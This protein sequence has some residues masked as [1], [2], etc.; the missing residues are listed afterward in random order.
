MI[1]SRAR[2]QIVLFVCLCLA[3]I[4]LVSCRRDKPKQAAKTEG[5]L[6]Y[7]DR[8]TYC[9]KYVLYNGSHGM[10]YLFDVSAGT[11]VPY[12]FDPGCEHK[13]AVRDTN[14]T[15][16]TEGCSAYDYSE[17]AVFLCDD[18]MYYFSSRCLYRAD[19]DGTNRKKIVEL[20]KPYEIRP[21]MCCYTDE[22]LYVSY[23]LSYEYTQTANADG[24]TVW[25]AGEFRE[26]PE[27]GLLRLPFSGG[28]EEVVFSSD[29]L[30]AMQVVEIWQH[31]KN[32]AFLVQ[33]MDRLTNYEEAD[34]EDW[35]AFSAEE[36]KHTFL[37]VYDYSV[38]DRTV[39]SVLDA[40]PNI[41]VYFYSEVYAIGRESGELEL[42][43]YSG[44]RVCSTE[45]KISPSVKCDRAIIGWDAATKE[46][47]M[48]SEHTGKIEK[49]SSLTW[50]DIVLTVTVGDSYYGSVTNPDGRS[51][52][53]YISAN[54][55]WAGNKSGIVVFPEEGEN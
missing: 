29:E 50:E 52:R 36:K 26:K 42:F 53:A 16:I 43:N 11:A 12:C 13:K 31:E 18:C 10:K 45:I 51:V 27:A 20:S 23:T 19:R 28:K 41:D 33:G 47:V 14:G 22:A 49:R 3:S 37:A 4:V 9:E 30:Y 48:L 24:T 44:K 21:E 32:V 46:G 17:L 39:V 8:G 15:I 2:R 6:F 1:S 25:L 54:D 35:Q 34:P 5:V 38:S 55:F 40:T 7:H